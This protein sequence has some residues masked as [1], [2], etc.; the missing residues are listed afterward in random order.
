[1][2]QMIRLRCSFRISCIA[3]VVLIASP[4]AAD[5]MTFGAA[6]DAT[7]YES[8]TGSLSGGGEDGIFV[9][10]TDTT[11]G[12][13]ADQRRGLIKFD[14]GSI[15]NGATINS[16]SLRLSVTRAPSGVPPTT[17]TL[18]RLLGDWGEGT[19]NPAGQG[20]GGAPAANGDATWLHQ[21]RPGDL[22][23]SPG[24]DFVSQASA[25]ASVGSSGFAT[26]SS[27]SQLVAD[28]QSWLA[29]PAENFGWLIHGNE[30]VVRT[31][32][33]FGSREF[34]APNS[35]PLLTVDFTLPPART[36][37]DVNDDSVVDA[38][39]VALLAASFGTTTTANNF[40]VGEFSGDGLVGLAD[41][42]IVQ[43]NFSAIGLAPSPAAVP[44][45][46]ALFLCIA[47]LAVIGGG[48]ARSLAAA[49]CCTR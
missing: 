8:L 25:S 16:V 38:A 6:K 14:V 24:G 36:P 12:A 4:V 37:G 31:A 17:M 43:R 39:D 29:N 2:Q 30:A 7:L 49:K 33:K 15:P 35:R 40:D 26:W 11:P 27:S 18:H 13:N 5:V 28:V 20:G 42:A 21:F 46:S 41:L 23:N 9:G 47:A 34:A 10:R 19:V 44:E 32:R 45:P 48:K 22:W 1:M 3:F